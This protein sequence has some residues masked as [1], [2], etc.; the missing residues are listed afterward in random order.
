MNNHLSLADDIMEGY[1]DEESEDEVTRNSD[2]QVPTY[3][4][5]YLPI[6]QST[7]LQG[8]LKLKDINT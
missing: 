3:L 5:I 4:P 1:V 2:V 8:P 6:Y 7:Y